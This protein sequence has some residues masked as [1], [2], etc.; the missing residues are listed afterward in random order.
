MLLAGMSKPP[1]VL[2]G[3]PALESVAALPGIDYVMA[4]I[5]GAAGLLPTLAAAKAGKRVLLANKEAL[6][7]AGPLL[8]RAVG[9]PWC[10]DP[11]HRQ[12]AQCGVSVP[13]A[14]TRPRAA[15]SG[16]GASC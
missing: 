11:A 6:V 16:V 3:A 1:E 14:W 5:V 7:M 2:A 9:G 10:G 12:R 4:A 13:A 8:M 15:K